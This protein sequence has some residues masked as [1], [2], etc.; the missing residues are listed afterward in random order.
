MLSL[1]NSETRVVVNDRRG[2]LKK[3]KK[4]FSCIKKTPTA[5]LNN[6]TSSPLSLSTIRS[7]RRRR[8]IAGAIIRD[9]I[10]VFRVKLA[11]IFILIIIAEYFNNI[12]IHV[13]RVQYNTIY[14]FKY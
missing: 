5:T 1:D 9:T 10:D 2:K 4:L 7:T 8:V 3:K 13:A 6:S 12:Y 11:D 14:V